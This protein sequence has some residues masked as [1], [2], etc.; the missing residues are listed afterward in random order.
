MLLYIRR[1]KYNTTYVWKIIK[2]LFIYERLKWL[3]E[4]EWD[5]QRENERE[6]KRDSR[7]GTANIRYF[8]IYTRLRYLFREHCFSILQSGPCPPSHH[9]KRRDY[10]LPPLSL[11]LEEK[12]FRI[13]IFFGRLRNLSYAIHVVFPP[14]SVYLKTKLHILFRNP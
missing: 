11:L 4:W 8:Q 5:R 10:S 6:R 2:S 3:R 9:P 14:Y 12:N 13:H 7:S 1:R